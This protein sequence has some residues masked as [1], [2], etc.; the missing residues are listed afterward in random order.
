MEEMTVIWCP[1]KLSFTANEAE[2]E[3]ERGLKEE[4]EEEAAEE[5]DG[6][7][8]FPPL[9]REYCTTS[10]KA[11]LCLKNDRGTVLNFVFLEDG[12]FFVR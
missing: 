1:L 8:G 9:E 11:T 6:V 3:G 4:Q 2:E 10:E 5:E 12:P 7:D